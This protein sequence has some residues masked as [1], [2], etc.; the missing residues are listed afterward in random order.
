MKL[1]GTRR[2]AFLAAGL[3][4]L[5]CAWQA[6][7]LS[8]YVAEALESDYTVFSHGVRVGEFRTVC[9]IIPHND[10]KVLKFEA[11]TRI[12]NLLE[13]IT[14]VLRPIPSPAYIPIV[15]IFLGFDEE[16]KVFMI[17]FSC[18]WPILLNTYSGVRAVD[19]VQVVS[20]LV[21]GK[22]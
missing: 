4:F 10:K 19:P 16:M 22:S 1:S 6:A 9:S 13:P 21:A 12:H 18:F 20:V 5:L 3:F 14:E 8:A 7:D 11:K 15:I 2:A 17:A